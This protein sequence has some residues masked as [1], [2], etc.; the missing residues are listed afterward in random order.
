MLTGWIVGSASI[1]DRWLLEALLDYLAVRWDRDWLEFAVELAEGLLQH[2]EDP[3]QGGFYFSDV[4]VQVPMMRSMNF[5][6]DATPNGN[7]VACEP[8]VLQMVTSL[9]PRRLASCIAAS[10]STDSPD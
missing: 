3:D 8:G 7:G 6:D 1:N 4:S 10:V 2:F 5:H 9:A